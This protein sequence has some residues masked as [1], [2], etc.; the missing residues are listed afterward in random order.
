V[1]QLAERLSAVEASLQELGVQL[2]AVP[3][4]TPQIGGDTAIARFPEPNSQRGAMQEHHSCAGLHQVEFQERTESALAELSAALR[5]QAAEKADVAGLSR[6]SASVQKLTQ[7][8]GQNERMLQEVHQKLTPAIQ[9]IRD[10]VAK[11]SHTLRNVQE[12]LLTKVDQ[13]KFDELVAAKNDIAEDVDILGKDLHNEISQKMGRE[14]CSNRQDELS[15]QV[16]LDTIDSIEALRCSLA[17]KADLEETTSRI[18]G[19]EIMLDQRPNRQEVSDVVLQCLANSRRCS[20]RH[21][22]SASEL[23]I[24][25]LGSR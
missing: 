18:H 20:I 11:T 6:V 5:R 25:S 10:Q 21:T 8:M 19:L 9:N 15:R 14:E 23:G 1:A 3:P 7:S 2:V 22:G 12:V 4:G 24:R 13:Q 17:Q 16:F